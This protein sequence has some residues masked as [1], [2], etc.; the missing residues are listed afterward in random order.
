M[1]DMLVKLYDLPDVAQNIENLKI[2][3]IEI[4]RALAT[5]KNKIVNWVR[6]TFNNE[7]AN[8]CDAAFCNK[9]VS[10]FLALE[11]FN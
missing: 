11:T 9:P 7:C 4:R 1:P 6:S 10:C 3:R 2:Y 5:D 8:E